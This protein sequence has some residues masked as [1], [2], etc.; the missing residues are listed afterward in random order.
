MKKGKHIS[1]YT[2]SIP[3]QEFWPEDVSEEL[4]SRAFNINVEGA[5]A[6]SNVT[7][8]KD[9]RFTNSFAPGGDQIAGKD[10]S[11]AILN[12][13]DDVWILVCP[14]DDIVP[15]CLWENNY[16]GSGFED[17]EITIGLPE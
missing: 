17:L 7:C 11:L 10:W 8:K 4:K 5:F 13:A 9:S 12:V 1:D 6:A 14:G 2:R 15:G 3:V 16:I